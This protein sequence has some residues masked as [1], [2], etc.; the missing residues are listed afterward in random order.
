MKLLWLAGTVSCWKINVA[1]I[2]AWNLLILYKDEVTESGF[3][4]FI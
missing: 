3:Y 1:L 2:S 4:L